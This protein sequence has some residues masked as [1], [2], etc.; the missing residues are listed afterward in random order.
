MMSS[1]SF[2]IRKKGFK[3]INPKNFVKKLNINLILAKVGNQLSN[4]NVGERDVISNNKIKVS[5]YRFLKVLKHSK[6]GGSDFSKLGLKFHTNNLY[7]SFVETE[8]TK[9]I[10]ILREKIKTAKNSRV[11]VSFFQKPSFVLGPI[12]KRKNF[13]NLAKGLEKFENFYSDYSNTGAERRAFFKT[14]KVKRFFPSIFF[15][16]LFLYAAK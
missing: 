5:F 2:L 11:V 16:R 4:Q 6:N 7:T 10:N 3:L 1:Q 9:K 8:K 15:S 13:S 12:K 14:L